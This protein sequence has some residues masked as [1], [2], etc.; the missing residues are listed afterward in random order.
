MAITGGFPEVQLN[1]NV[2][3]MPKSA[4]LA[5]NERSAWLERQGRAVHRLGLGQA[6]FPVPESVVAALRANAHQND[7]LSVQGLDELREV[8]AKVGCRIRSSGTE[9]DVVDRR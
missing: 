5:I 2:R 4:T 9:A 3:G 8:I 7:Y 1:V 6:P